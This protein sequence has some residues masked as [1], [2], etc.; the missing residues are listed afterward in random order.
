MINL[1]WTLRF[2][3]VGMGLQ[4]ILSSAAERSVCC[5]L[6]ADEHLLSVD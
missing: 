6:A 2:E 1:G 5:D 4:R 3:V